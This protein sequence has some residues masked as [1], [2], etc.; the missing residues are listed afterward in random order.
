MTID[1]MQIVHFVTNELKLSQLFTF[2]TMAG[3]N[4]VYP[5]LI[6]PGFCCLENIQQP[7]YSET[8]IMLCVTNAPSNNTVC[9]V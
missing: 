9:T 5:L 6:S 8:E 4:Q 2:L 7:Q 1:F 3:S